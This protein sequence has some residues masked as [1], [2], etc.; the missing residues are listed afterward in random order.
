MK[1]YFSLQFKRLYRLIEENGINPYLVYSALV[2]LFV[3]L[4]E[5][6]FQKTL[7]AGY[8]Y[9]VLASGLINNLGN[10]K[11]N[12]FL[13]NCFSVVMYKRIRAIENLLMA[14]PF[15]IFLLY[16]KLF[17]LA[18]AVY[19]I[20]A[21]LSLLNKLNRGNVTIPTPFY[22]KP[23][24]FT[25]GFR[26]TFW[27][28][29]LAYILTIIAINQNNFYLAVFALMIT[30]FVCIG[31]Y[32]KPETVFYV[33]IYSDDTTAFLL[34]K[35]KT[36]IA[37]SFFLSMPILIFLFIFFPENALIIL[38]AEAVGIFL[39]ITSLLGKYAYFPSEVN[40]IPGFFIALSIVLPPLLLVI[41]PYFYFKSKKNISS[42]LK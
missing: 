5:L 10:R 36:A 27:I 9:L 40:L 13:K 16:K 1:Y 30:F 11:R 34:K 39:V 41:L 14:T 20:A 24:E 25:V 4:S 42:I 26:K 31:F 29:L 18:I 19:A 33:W 37:Y 15:F 17:V 28:F 38:I 32:A 22:K 23:F 21:G 35:V 12:E 2:F 8:I 6:L 7:Y 3:L